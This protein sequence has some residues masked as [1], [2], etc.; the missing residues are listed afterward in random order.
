MIELVWAEDEFLADEVAAGRRA[1]LPPDA[2]TLQ[3]S[4]EGGEIAGLEEALFAPSLFTASRLV[5]VRGAERLQSEGIRRLVEAAGRRG[6]VG[7]V[8]AVAVSERP[9]AA[10][11]KALAGLA[12]VRKLPRPKRGELIAWVQKRF[13]AS[14]VSPGQ[15]VPGLVLEAVGTNLRELAQ[16]VDQLVTHAGPGGTVEREDVHRHFRTLADQPVW[17]LFDA[18]C[19]ADDQRAFRVLRALLEQG[20]DPI[21][22]LFAL[23][24][25]LRAVMRAKAALEREP[26][27]NEVELAQVLGV[28]PGRAAVLRKQA[29][30]LAWPWMLRLHA[31]CAS[32][33]FELKGGDE[34]KVVGVLPPEIVLER[35]VDE[36]LPERGA[37][38]G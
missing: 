1:A 20:D 32:A 3:L 16:A 19:A 33:D 6:L 12:E 9:P 31:A 8:L 2:E 11:T 24:S 30:R 18:V 5:I 26:S 13:R 27:L 29:G 23:V 4:V 34:V 35:L 28:S 17:A 38:R 7:D 21:A 22:V 36:A 14:K 37:V 15:D 25:Q 10:L